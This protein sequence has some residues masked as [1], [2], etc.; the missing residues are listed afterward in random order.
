V[1]YAQSAPRNV[2]IAGIGYSQGK[3]EADLQARWQSSY[4][5]FRMGAGLTGLQPVTVQN[6]V[7]ANGRIAYRVLENVTFALMLQQFNQARIAETAGPPVERRV[8]LSATARF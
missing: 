4:L 6:Y 8:I 5:D 3:W 2:V 7:T 1:E